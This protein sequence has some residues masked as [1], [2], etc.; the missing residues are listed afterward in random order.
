MGKFFKKTGFGIALAAIISLGTLILLIG[1]PDASR[2]RNNELVL[3]SEGLA[4]ASGASIAAIGEE[5]VAQGVPPMDYGQSWLA[6]DSANHA[7]VVYVTLWAYDQGDIY[8]VN[9]LSGSWSIPLKISGGEGGM[10]PQ[11]CLDNQGKCH[12]VYISPDQ[13]QLKYTNNVQGTWSSPIAVPS[14]SNTINFGFALSSTGNP[15]IVYQTYESDGYGGYYSKILYTYKEGF[16]WGDPLLVSGSDNVDVDSTGLSL[17]LDGNDKAHTAYTK[18]NEG[19]SSKYATNAGGSWI[20]EDVPVGPYPDLD[21]DSSGKVHLVSQD[22]LYSNNVFGGWS[23]A[24]SVR[25]VDD[26]D[27]IKA[28]SMDME[29][30]KCHVAY[31]LDTKNN[32]GGNVRYNTNVS[33]SW[34]SPVYASQRRI[35]ST[36]GASVSLDTGSDSVSRLVTQGWFDYGEIGFTTVLFVENSS[37]W[38]SHVLTKDQVNGGPSITIDSEDRPVVTYVGLNGDEFE[39]MSK[40]KSSGSWS[41]ASVASTNIA[42]NSGAELAPRRGDPQLAYRGWTESKWEV[43]HTQKGGAGWVPPQVATANSTSG[44]LPSIDVDGMAHAH[45]AYRGYTGIYGQPNYRESIYYTTNSGGSWLGG[46][47]VCPSDNTP[48]FPSLAVDSSNA[49]HIVYSTSGLLRY[50]YKSGTGWTSP[51]TL[52][53]GSAENPMGP[54]LA[55]GPGNKKVVVFYDT[56][57]HDNSLYYLENNGS[58]WSTAQ[59]IALPGMQWN[60]YGNGVDIALDG[61]GKCHIFFWGVWFD[62]YTPIYKGFYVHNRSGSWSSPEEIF[63]TTTNFESGAIAVDSSGNAHLAYSKDGKIYY[64]YK[65]EVELY[66]WYLAEGCTAG[67]MTTWICVQNPNPGP[68]YVTLILHT[69]HG[70]KKFPE[71]T[72]RLIGPKS[73]SSFLLNNFVTSD[74]VSTLVTSD[75]PVVVERA[76]YGS[77]MSWA[78]ASVGTTSTATSWYLAEGCTAGG[79]TTWVCVQ[80]PNQDPAHVS[81]TLHS[82]GG[83]VKIDQLQNVTIPGKSRESFPLHAYINSDRVSTLVTS[84]KP[85]VVER[86]MYGRGWSW[87]TASVGTTTPAQNWYFAE[88]CTAG[89]MTTWV[90]VQNPNP[91]PVEVDLILQTDQGEYI[92]PELTHYP[93]DARSRESFPLHLFIATYDVSTLVSSDLPVV[94]ERAMYGRGWSWATASIGYSQ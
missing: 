91:Y 75:K 40:V 70:E 24:Q 48:V 42:D 74:K 32:C 54:R 13:D 33:G 59:K 94:V 61:D 49:P 39:V 41:S 87:A 52:P 22:G 84:D 7:H 31:I 43:Y 25:G 34:A 27:A 1:N 53:K 8:Y 12:V 16:G 50:T 57:W 71:L 37:G 78:T 62:G 14:T 66:T 81:L 6:L 20:Q 83:E 21:L 3:G 45:V 88:G 2:P 65:G 35:N 73:R 38:A 5:L 44:Y 29:A 82:G 85:V 18:T 64:L 11:I 79:M 89:G 26:P 92:F 47:D 23:S 67:G 19:N 72:N 69:S 4:H 60:M 55:I 86:A 36:W 80:N 51:Q 30:D 90:C 10:W 28:L 58:G 76:M 46:V 93:I 56:K 68:A 63:S 17:A 77:G 9:N 15:H